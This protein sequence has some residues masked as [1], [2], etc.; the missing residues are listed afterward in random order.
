[1]L[2]KSVTGRTFIRFYYF[3]APAVARIVESSE[4]I[5]RMARRLLDKLVPIAEKKV[6]ERG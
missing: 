2:D 4:P 1:M 3:T 5:K 6:R